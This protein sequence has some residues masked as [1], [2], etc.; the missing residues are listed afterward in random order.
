MALNAT[1]DQMQLAFDPLLHLVPPQLLHL[2]HCYNCAALYYRL[3]DFNEVD[4]R[5]CYM[6][7]DNPVF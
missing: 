7:G 2:V 3:I 5:I 1:V 4:M 6:T